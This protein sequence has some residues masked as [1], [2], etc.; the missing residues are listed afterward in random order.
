MP[1]LIIRQYRREDRQQ[2]RDI[3]WETAFMGEP[4]SIFF[5]GKEILADFLTLYFT[6]Y[7]PESCF[8]AEVNARVV[9]YI[10]GSKDTIH[11]RKVFKSKIS[12]RLI[13][14]LISSGALLKKKNLIF[15]FAYLISFFKGE[16][17]LP[18]FSKSYPATVHINL[19]EGFRNLGLGSR[20]ISVYLDYLTREKISGVYLATL[21]SK[22]S[23]FFRKQ[24]FN[25]LYQGQ[26]SHFRNILHRDIAVYIFGYILNNTLSS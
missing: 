18:D 1:E 2:V 20:L 13:I 22:A 4:A 10:I 7:E 12:W 23:K 5:E 14:K 25:L 24:G 9:G 8:V 21:S 11:L 6:D 15:F 16:L 26:R 17:R 3:A 19:R